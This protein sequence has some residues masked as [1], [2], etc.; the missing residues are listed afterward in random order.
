VKPDPELLQIA[1]GVVGCCMNAG[2]LNSYILQR[3]ISEGNGVISIEE[4]TRI[5]TAV[6]E[7]LDDLTRKAQREA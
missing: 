3:S 6:Y 1:L 7:Q 4:T 5:A 2:F